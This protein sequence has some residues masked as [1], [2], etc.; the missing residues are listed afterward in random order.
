MPRPS[1]SLLWALVAI[2]AGLCIVAISLDLPWISG[3][4]TFV[5]AV[6]AAA[7][8]T[9]AIVALGRRLLWS[10]GRQ[11][12]LTYFLLGL[13]PI[14]MVLALLFVAA[15][16]LSGF[17]L[18]HLYREAI[19]DLEHELEVAARTRLAAVQ[20]RLPVPGSA[21]S[22]FTFGYYREGN[23]VGGD[24]RAP[25]QWPD[26]LATSSQYRR[27]AEADKT[28]ESSRMPSMI[29]LADG[30]LTVAATAPGPAVGVIAF[31]DGDLETHLREMSDV[32]VDLFREEESGIELTKVSLLGETFVL[33]PLS[34]GKGSE[35]MNA[36]LDARR[37]NA[38]G[39]T[40]IGFEL[41]GPSRS[42][43]DGTI[44]S[45]SV[46]ATLTATPSVVFGRLF[47][48]SAEVDTLGWIAFIVPA[49][50][51]FD[52]YALAVLMA[53]FMILG[54]TRAVNRLSKATAA[55]QEG[56]FSVRIPVRRND[57]LGELQRSFNQ[58]N[59]SL[60]RLVAEAAQKEV[61]ER[62]LDI[63]Q[64]V[65]K[66]LLPSEV[67]QG[68]SIEFATFF[69]PSAAI[70][71]DYYDIVELPD[72]ESGDLAV[73]IA[74]VA[75]HGLSSGLRMAMLK[76]GLLTLVQQGAEPEEI[77]GSLD[78]LVR[79]TGNRRSFVTATLAVI[80]ST[81]G[82]VDLTNAGHPPTYHLRNGVVT[83]HLLGGTPLGVL[84]ND[85]GHRKLQLEAGD[86]LVLLSDGFLEATNEA[87]EPFGYEATV[88]ALSA[89]FSSAAEVRDKLLRSV[90]EH[91][92]WGTAEDDRTLVVMRYRGSAAR[93]EAAPQDSP[94]TESPDSES[95]IPR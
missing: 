90:R 92:G 65:Q 18:G 10:V 78:H 75:G 60:E 49:F 93:Q 91:T 5:L 50:L 28:S 58:M 4:A 29:E 64:E 67:L 30:T 72:R 16:L 26:W 77:L 17:F 35:E 31:Y 52:V 63:A 46:T 69:E 27:S 14:P 81:T 61:L 73:V 6:G 48:S 13:L 7:G 11:L 44:A 88:E 71:G 40:V 22:G 15:Y 53:I 21:T 42:F 9:W 68:E 83:E 2:V 74:D 43:E 57:Q 80:D 95:A 62:E 54:V 34:R 87:G 86:L 45:S 25:E 82:M 1:K 47:S 12:S 79:S 85:F 76:A 89:P 39:M 84:E 36:F 94:V 33:Q 19:M 41:A 55:V 51:L 23:R 38:S 32:W 59:E 66:S 70:G 20:L 37:K 24:E 56:D 3:F 8:L